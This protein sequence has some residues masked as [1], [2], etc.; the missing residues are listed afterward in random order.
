MA[1]SAGGSSHESVIPVT[2][3]VA[4]YSTNFVFGGPPV[5]DG[6]YDNGR[7]YPGLDWVG[8]SATGDWRFFMADFAEVPE[9]ASLIVDTRWDYPGSDIDT[10]IMGPVPSDFSDN[11]PDYYG[12]YALD[13]LGRSEDTYQGRGKWI[14]RTATGTNRELVTAPAQ[15]GLHLFAL[16]NVVF[17]G[18]ALSEGFTGQVGLISANPPIV[19]DLELTGSGSVTVTVNATIPLPDLVAEGFGLGRPEV[20]TDQVAQQD[21]PED[22][23]TASYTRTVTIEHAAR[24]DVQVLGQEGDDLDLY[25]Y[26]ILDG[27]LIQ[28]GASFTPPAEEFVSI[29]FPP[30]GQYLIAVHGWS[31]PAGT[32][33]F[34]LIVNRVQG[35]DLQVRDVPSGP[36]PPGQDITFVL[37]W[38][39]DLAEGESAEGVL[40]IG[41]SMAPGALQI[42]VIITAPTFTQTV[43]T[44]VPV[45]MDT[46]IHAGEP[47]LNFGG[48]AKLRVGRNDTYRALLWGDVSVVPSP[49]PVDR[50]TLYVWVDSFAGGGSP[51]QLAA[52][53]VLT[54]WDEP[55][56][57]WNAPW[58]TPGGDFDPAP[59]GTTT[60]SGADA[61][62]WVAIDITP[63]VRKWVADP[64]TNLGLVL[65]ATGESLTRFYL[66]S[67]EYWDPA[68]R[69]YIE[70]VYREPTP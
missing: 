10:I 2:V 55:T 8:T 14:W 36:F 3:N 38:T 5:S 63:L 68:T 6:R 42:P 28:V 32:T 18:D 20:Y 60:I 9:N 13:T 51:H 52:H 7:M 39:K 64:S 56:T 57:T 41:P 67:S 25:V 70:I 11:E 31:V 29:T 35:Y 30:D 24:L 46:D 66:A 34:D 59:V 37:D 49:Y 48:W 61:G 65:R 62:Q 47:D 4:A 53:E 44:T 45:V 23:A 43:T 40:T 22:P 15:P 12:P 33:T 26:Y 27:E 50:A 21:D 16:H 1:E 17:G 69:P 58:S 54:P 19:E